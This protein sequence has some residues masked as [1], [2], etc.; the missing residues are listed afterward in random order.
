MYIRLHK[1]VNK[2]EPTLA[3]KPRGDQVKN[4]VCLSELD[5]E[6]SML[7]LSTLIGL[8]LDIISKCANI[9]SKP[10][11]PKVSSASPEIQNRGTSG[12]KKGHVSAKNLKKKNSGATVYLDLH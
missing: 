2:A 10:T 12:P 5:F 8:P 7:S 11:E 3:L 6:I 1:K 9:L 4:L